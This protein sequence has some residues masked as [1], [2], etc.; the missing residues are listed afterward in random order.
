[1][2]GRKILKKGII[3]FVCIVLISATLRSSEIILNIWAGKNLLINEKQYIYS[4]FNQYSI[5]KYSPE[6]NQV[7]KIGRKGEGPGDIKRIGWFAINPKNKMIYVTEIVNG[8]RR[9]SIF[10]PDDGKYIDNWKFDFNWNEWGGIPCIQFDHMGNIYIEVVRSIW[11]RH[12]SFSIGALEK[13]I[14]KYSDSGIKIKELYRLKSDFMAEKSGKGNITIPYC[15]YLYWK[16]DKDRIVIR[17]NLKPYIS[18]FDLNGV[19]IKMLKLPFKQEKLTN[20]DLDE[21]ERGL[22]SYPNIKIG[23]SEGWFAVKFW[24]KNLPFPKFKGICGGELFFDSDGCVYSLKCP[25]EG[26]KEKKWAKIN[27]SSWG[28]DLIDFPYHYKLKCIKDN[29]FYFKTLNENDEYI[30]VKID[31]ESIK[32]WKTR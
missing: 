24:R 26:D 12:K 22:L 9:V 14:L 30:L 31:K 1:M 4:H 19:L 28:I 7:L 3:L 15:N 2:N 18:V 6:G 20:K 11:R 17:E 5:M 23:I 21:W 8:N 16:I 25:G 27:M 13:A 32:K 29:Y 10:S